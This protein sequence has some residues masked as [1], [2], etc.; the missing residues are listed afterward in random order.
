M[1]YKLRKAPNRDLY[2]VIT[3]ETG[4]KHSKEPILLEKAKAQKRILEDALVGGVGRR[5]QLDD[6]FNEAIRVYRI[7]THRK[8]RVR[9]I[10]TRVKQRLEELGS[11]GSTI[12][13]LFGRRDDPKIAAEKDRV[14][15][16]G[17]R[18]ISAL[19]H[20]PQTPVR[21]RQR[22]PGAIGNI[23]DLINQG[24][25][26]PVEEDEDPDLAEIEDELGDMAGNPTGLG[27][28]GGGYWTDKAKSDLTKVFNE[29]KSRNPAILKSTLESVKRELK[30]APRTGKTSTRL[31]LTGNKEKEKIIKNAER[32]LRKQT[33]SPLAV[34]RFSAD[35]G[36]DTYNPISRVPRVPA[37]NPEYGVPVATI[38][39][40]P[41]G[42]VPPF[43]G[44]D[45]EDA[46]SSGEPVMVSSGR[47]KNGGAGRKKE[48]KQI[49][50]LAFATPGLTNVQKTKLRMAYSLIN[51]KLKELGPA[52]STLGRLVGKKDD[53]ALVAEKNR[54]FTLGMSAIDN[55]I[56]EDPPVATI[57]P[58]QQA[59]EEQ[60][61]LGRCRKCNGLKPSRKLRFQ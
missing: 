10:Y 5:Q 52:G 55:I 23:N 41:V 46:S 43:S 53:P 35:G 19:A 54:V 27:N 48:W 6:A 38:V 32:Q 28:C 45:Y 20:P 1:P 49:F 22:G 21:L 61:G 36:E 14:L 17:L 8:T 40:R 18:A 51:A 3:S 13:R 44:Y 25:P 7:P 57:V 4:K 31:N 11:A 37:F 9:Q 16:L 2:W 47:G 39:P 24:R 15:R 34:P 59:Q 30:N 33:R 60:V 56:S 26:V 29:S 42:Q 50:D 12:G 58:V